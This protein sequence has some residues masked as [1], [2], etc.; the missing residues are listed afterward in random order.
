MSGSVDEVDGQVLWWLE[1]RK[2][3]GG[4]KNKKMKIIPGKEN[5]R[6]NF[7]FYMRGFEDGETLVFEMRRID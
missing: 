5:D 2:N 1:K 4:W 3:K 6:G 7:F